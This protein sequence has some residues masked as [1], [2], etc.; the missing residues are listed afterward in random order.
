LVAGA[1]RVKPEPGASAGEAES[2]VV[3]GDVQ[4][5]LFVRHVRRRE[6][7]EREDADW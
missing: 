1:S 4:D 3:F 5:V 2:E 6:E 7:G